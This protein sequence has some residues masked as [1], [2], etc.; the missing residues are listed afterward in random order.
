MEVRAVKQ[1]KSLLVDVQVREVWDKVV[2][3]KESHENPIIDHALQDIREAQA[4]LFGNSRWRSEEY[5]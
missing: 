1:R 5:V 4:R 3:Y 2:S